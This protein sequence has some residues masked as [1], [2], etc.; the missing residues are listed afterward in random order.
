MRRLLFLSLGLLPFQVKLLHHGVILITRPTHPFLDLVKS[1]CDAKL[2]LA[3]ESRTLFNKHLESLLLRLPHH[4]EEVRVTIL[5]FFLVYKLAL[6]LDFLHLHLPHLAVH[7]HSIH[8]PLCLI[9]FALP[10]INLLLFFLALQNVVH[11]SH[12]QVS[13]LLPYF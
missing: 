1:I 10:I 12:D 13:I 11:P 5:A 9:D 8:L 3:I 4:I 7:V 6:K 2:N